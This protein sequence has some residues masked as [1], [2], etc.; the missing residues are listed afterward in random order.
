M[1]LSRRLVGIYSSSYRQS[2]A[3]AEL[4]PRNRAPLGAKT[5]N[6]RALQTPAPLNAEPSP[7]KASIKTV[8]PRLRRAKVKIHQAQS[9]GFEDVEERDIEYMPPRAKRKDKRPHLPRDNILMTLQPFQTT[10]P[11]TSSVPPNHSPNSLPQ[12]SPAAGRPSTLST[13]MASHLQTYAKQN[14]KL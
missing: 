6:A 14:T 5:T 11:T 4:G 12:T 1:P 7:D 13:I 9:V 8:S 3:N 2:V 10:L